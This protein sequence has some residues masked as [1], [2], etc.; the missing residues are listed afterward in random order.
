MKALFVCWADRTLAELRLAKAP[1][2]A[3]EVGK[4]SSDKMLIRAGNSVVTAGTRKAEV[5]DAFFVSVFADRALCPMPT[6]L[7]GKER[8]GEQW[9]SGGLGAT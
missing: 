9:G 8:D 5:L 6:S 3:D 2:C 7:F 1:A 4:E